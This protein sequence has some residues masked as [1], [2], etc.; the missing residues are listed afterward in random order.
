MPPRYKILISVLAL[1][2]TFV[3]FLVDTRMGGGPSRWIALILGPMMVGAI[4]LFPETRG[5][6]KD[7]QREA[8]ER[9]R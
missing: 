7:I 4:W 5:K 2:V 9:R 8:A 3:V 1:I 6:P